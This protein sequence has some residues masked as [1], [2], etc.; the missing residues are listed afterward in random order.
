MTLLIVFRF[1]FFFLL[2]SVVYELTKF[3]VFGDRFLAESVVVYLLVY[4]F[5][6]TL[7]KLF[8]KKTNKVDLLL[9]PLFTWAVLFLGEPF[10]IVTLL[11]FGAYFL[12]PPRFKRKEALFYVLSF[13]FPTIITLGSL[14][15]SGY[16]FNLIVENRVILI[17]EAESQPLPIRLEKSLFLSDISYNF[18]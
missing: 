9:M 4:Q 10:T 5:G 16:Y 15:L 8:F 6:I 12:S 17:S 18:H 11:L 13:I 1:G 3:Y 14:N 2:F 7:E